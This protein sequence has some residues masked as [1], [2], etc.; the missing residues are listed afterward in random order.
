MHLYKPK[1]QSQ[2]L[3]AFRVTNRKLQLFVDVKIECLM[4]IR[5]LLNE[6]LTHLK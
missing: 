3:K 1:A 2:K 5:V 6:F 4:L